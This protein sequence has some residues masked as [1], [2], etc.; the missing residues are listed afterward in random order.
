MAG[1][2]IGGKGVWGALVYCGLVV[3]WMGEFIW[4]E[5]WGCVYFLGVF[6]VFGWG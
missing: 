4:F 5:V 2:G 6:D 1:V 3:E